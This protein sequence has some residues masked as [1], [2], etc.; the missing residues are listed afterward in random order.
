MRKIYGARAENGRGDLVLLEFD[1]VDLEMFFNSR[2]RAFRFEPIC[3]R[4][5]DV[6]EF[7]ADPPL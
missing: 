6:V 1:L 2:G 4:L 5:K 3:I 7:G